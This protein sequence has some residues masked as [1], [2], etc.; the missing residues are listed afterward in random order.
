MCFLSHPL[1]SD[2]F[3]ASH[4]KNIGEALRKVYSDH[5]WDEWK[6]NMKSQGFFKDV[7]NQR[8]FILLAARQLGV[9]TISQWYDV[10]ARTIAQ[11]DGGS[12]RFH[13]QN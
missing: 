9:E 10:D 4:Y 8:K 1:I 6:L 5:V 2:T 11:L 3:V 7:S 13:M 12:L